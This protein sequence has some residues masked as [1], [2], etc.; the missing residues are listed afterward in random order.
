[1]RSIRHNL[2]PHSPASIPISRWSRIPWIAATSHSGNC[3]DNATLLVI[4]ASMLIRRRSAR[5]VTP[6]WAI[7]NRSL[8]DAGCDA[9]DIG[10]HA[11][12]VGGVV[13][14]DHAHAAPLER[15]HQPLVPAPIAHRDRRAAGRHGVRHLRPPRQHQ[16]QRAGP[17]LLRQ[18]RSDL[19]PRG[20]HAG[21]LLETRDVD[22]HGIRARPALGREDF[23]HGPF[24]QGVRA[25]AVDRLGGERDQPA[26]LQKAGGARDRGRIGL[27][28][29][30]G[31]DG[32]HGTV[33]GDFAV[34]ISSVLR[35]K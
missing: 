19:R 10:A 32:G 13:D 8:A 35:Y 4:R 7:K 29:I 33:P 5:I 14:L 21:D 9:P 17:E 22:D 2:A 15:P 20:R 18:S 12:E 25:E 24:I 28:R 27:R 23:L 3:C 6:G 30:D 16:R 11:I 31:P 1:M 34:G 26:A